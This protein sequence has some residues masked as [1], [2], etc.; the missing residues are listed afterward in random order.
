MS[1]HLSLVFLI[2][3]IFFLSACTVWPERPASVFAQA[4]GGEELERVFWKE[5]K[6][7]HWDEVD[8]RLA[9]NYVSINSEGQHDRVATMQRLRQLELKDYSLGDFQTE[10]NG[11]TFV[12]AYTITLHGTRNGEPLPE[13]PQR[14]LTVW[15]QQ[16][17]GWVEIAHSTLAPAAK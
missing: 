2:W 17:K 8:H 5:I 9:S 6:A 16:A 3:G 13:G 14:V 12:V 10:L 7:K 1:R 11:N 15:Q 4:L